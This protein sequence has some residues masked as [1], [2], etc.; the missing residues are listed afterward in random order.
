MVAQKIKNLPTVQ[1]T[2]VQFLGQNDP[3]ENGMV[4]TPVLLP[5]E[6]RGQSSLVGYNP[7]SCIELDMAE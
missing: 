2:W 6:F 3:L 1:E 5:A 7:R 4:T